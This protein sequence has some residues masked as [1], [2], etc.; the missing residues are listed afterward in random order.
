MASDELNALHQLAQRYEMGWDCVKTELSRTMTLSKGKRVTE[1]H[2]IEIIFPRLPKLDISIKFVENDRS[3][4][5]LYHRIRLYPS[6][7][8][9]DESTQP[10]RSQHEVERF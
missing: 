3:S 2:N 6:V 5:L 7:N 9:T 4:P 8:T 1:L 10:C